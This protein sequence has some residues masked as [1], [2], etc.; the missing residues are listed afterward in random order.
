MRYQR[1]TCI[2][3]ENSLEIFRTKEYFTE[4]SLDFYLYIFPNSEHNCPAVF[5][6]YHQGKLKKEE[7]S[8]LYKGK[9]RIIMFIFQYIYYLIF[10]KKLKIKKT[11]I[12]VADLHFVFFNSIVKFFTGNRL[13]FWI[14]D[15]L[16]DK[17]KSL[18][19]Y[20]FDRLT[21]FYINSLKYVFFSSPN[22]R[23]LYLKNYQSNDDKKVI[24]LGIKN[25]PVN[26]Q[27]VPNLFGFIGNLRK[28]QGLELIIEVLKK[29]K[30]YYFEVVGKGEYGEILKKMAKENNVDNQ[31]SFLGYLEYQKIIDISSRWEAALAAYDPSSKNYTYYADPGKI[32]LYIELEVPIIMTDITYLAEEIKDSRSGE[33]V[34]Y[35]TDGIVSGIDKIQNDYNVYIVGIKKMKDKYFYKKIYKEGFSVLEEQI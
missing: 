20:I 4:F 1:I 3:N 10:L 6:H 2:T 21:N 30:N 26:R 19:I 28:E 35:N 9:N 11:Y 13:V 25:F 23:K 29:N 18:P 34:N 31:I 32:K 5:R 12:I 33:I 27:P 15:G 16:P 7:K 14:G 22:L 17:Y 8:F 24:T